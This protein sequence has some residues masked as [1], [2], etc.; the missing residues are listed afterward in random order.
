MKKVLFLLLII[1]LL[2]VPAYADISTIINDNT[3]TINCS[4]DELKHMIVAISTD[5]EYAVGEV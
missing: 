3:I 2:S 5:S 1:T 4:G